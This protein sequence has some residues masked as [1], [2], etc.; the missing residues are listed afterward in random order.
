LKLSD[1]SSLLPNLPP[2]AEILVA[3]LRSLG[4]MV[5]ETPA[6][7]ALHAWRPDVRIFVLIEQRFA[8]ALE[9]NPAIAGLIF[10]RGFFETVADIRHHRFPAMFNQHGGPRSALLTA[11]SGAQFR[12][13][14][15]G[16][17]Y[18]WVYNV[19]VPDADEFYGK[20]IVHTVEHR[21]SQFYATGLPRGPIPVARIYPQNDAVSRVSK[22]LAG[23]GVAAPYAVLQPEARTTEMRWP[24]EKFAEIAHW[25]SEKHGIAS[26]A[27]LSAPGLRH[28]AEMR[29]AFANAAI[30]P[31]PLP[32]AE[33]IALISGARLFIGNDSG[34]VHLAAASGT[35]A[36]VI[37]GPTNPAQWRPWQSEHRVVSTGAQFRALRGDK[38]IAVNEPRPI[39]AIDVAEVRAACE[40]LLSQ[41]SS[42]KP[43]ENLHNVFNQAKTS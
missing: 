9:G 22:L 23:H 26:I 35:P 36:V 6:L 24:A 15:K 16:F 2:G 42:R 12:V 10:S 7:A 13:G 34:P 4:D 41:E 20:P 33:L 43:V 5:L 17:Q 30:I 38:T 29:H 11:A 21:M 37:Y 8:P 19:R 18:S 31:E 1:P 25:L 3:R 32:L 40:Q 39:S 27:N 14:W 28:A